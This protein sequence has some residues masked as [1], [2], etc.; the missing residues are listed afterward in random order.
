MSKWGTKSCPCRKKIRSKPKEERG[1]LLGFGVGGGVGLWDNRCERDSE[2]QLQA[3]GG[4][5]PAYTL[6]AMR[7]LDEKGSLHLR[8]LKG[9]AFAIEGK[10]EEKGTAH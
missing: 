3:K 1:R 6:S 8:F 7:E 9:G 2:Q 5:T 10:K 4:G